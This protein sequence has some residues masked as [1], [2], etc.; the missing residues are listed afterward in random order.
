MKTKTPIDLS[1]YDF[2]SPIFRQISD[3]PIS[4][5]IRIIVY[6]GDSL[7]LEFKQISLKA[8]TFYIDPVS[9]TIA[10]HLTHETKSKNEAWIINNKYNVLLLDAT[11]NPILNPDFNSEKEITLDNLPY[12]T[13]PAFERFAGFM[14]RRNNPVA[15]PMI[16]DLSV[17]SDDANGYFD[18]KES[19]TTLVDL[20]KEIYNRNKSN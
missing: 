10:S 7:D 15:L 4:K 9:K 14:L 17:N 3:D 19:H 2:Q 1:N 5:L 13:Q 12:K 11:G 16:W 18:Y 6:Y 20:A 8:K